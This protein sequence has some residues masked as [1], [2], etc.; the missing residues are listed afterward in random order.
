MK[1]EKGKWSSV[2]FIGFVFALGSYVSLGI[3][4]SSPP[5]GYPAGSTGDFLGANNTYYNICDKEDTP[6]KYEQCLAKYGIIDDSFGGWEYAGEGE[7]Q[8]CMRTKTTIG[9]TGAI[10]LKEAVKKE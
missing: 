10:N 6:L 4:F 7:W 8:Y 3:N 2:L 5:Q 9:C 1:K